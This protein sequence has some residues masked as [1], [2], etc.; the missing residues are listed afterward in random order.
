MSLDGQTRP[1]QAYGKDN[2]KNFYRTGY[3][4]S[5]TLAVSGGNESTNFRLS[6]GNTKDESIM[7]G[8]NFGRNN[9]CFEFEFKVNEKISIETNAAVYV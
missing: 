5:N 1:Y 4:F 2:I 9:V 7:P 8:T 6:F 3:S